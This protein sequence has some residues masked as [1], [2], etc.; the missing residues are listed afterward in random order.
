MYLIPV[1]MLFLQT[2]PVKQLQTPIRSTTPKGISIGGNQI[3]GLGN[4]KAAAAGEIDSIAFGNGARTDVAAMKSITIGNNSTVG[5]NGI[6]SVVIG[7]GAS[8]NVANS[9]VLG[10]RS[11]ATIGAEA[12]YGAY[13]LISPQS[14]VGE[15]SVGSIGNTRK[16]TNVAAGS[17][18]TDAVNV[19][20]LQ[21]INDGAV[22]YDTRQILVKS[23]ISLEGATTKDGGSTNGTKITNL[24]KGFIGANSSDAVNGSQLY[25][26]TQG[27]VTNINN[28]GNSTATNLGGGSVYDSTTGIISS[29]TYNVYGTTQTNVGSAITVL[30][31]SAPLQYANSSGVATP[32]VPSNYV[33]LVGGAA[34]P[35]HITNVANAID[36][37]D[38]VNKSQL[39]AVQG[40]IS[41]LD[42]LAVKYDNSSKDAITFAG[43]TSLDGGVTGGTTLFNIH[44]G[45]LRS[46]ST[47]AVNGAQL[48]ATNQSIMNITNGGGIKYFRA[49]SAATDALA[50]GAESVAIGPRSISSGD[51]SV[52]IGD[53]SKAT[54]NGAISIGQ[55]SASSGNNAIAIGTGAIATGSV[56]IG[57][58]AQAGNGGAAFG[59]NAVALAP[60]QGTALGNAAIVTSKRGVALGAGAQST[61]AGMNGSSEK[62]SNISV[63]SSEGAV[64]V[65]SVGNERQITNVAGSTAD[66]DAV[67]VR[68]LDAA[69]AQTNH[70]YDNQFNNIRSTIDKVDKN[71]SAGSAASIAMASMPHAVLPGKAMMTAGI[72]YYEG[73]SA[74]AIGV[75]NFSENGRWIVNLNGSANTRGKV[76]AG[77]G[78]GMHW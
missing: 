37:N 8:V 49:N 26:I 67:N 29:P 56:A 3:S 35:V 28:L 5:A 10:A 38:A 57:A 75:S 76:G 34:G 24:A 55:N 39:D 78:I 13:G 48:Y 61:R 40:S 21:A 53:N 51:G 70:Y 47:E 33:T 2:L 23:L 15:V 73:Q 16:I 68:Q 25:N 9:V 66:T 74:L 43:P 77:V 46:T 12:N 1:V 11:T 64:S 63:T 44:Q 50:T 17:A 6:N 4:G 69:I 30:Q 60:Q 27:F 52:A 14:N 31:T 36:A 32:L 54:K 41:N 72:G 42:A 7:S 22:K 62:Y 20:Q 71:A 45:V 58:G 18:A 19:S 59:D 65:G